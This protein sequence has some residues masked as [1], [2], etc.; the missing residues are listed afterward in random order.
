MIDRNVEG[1]YVCVFCFF[2]RRIV[3]CLLYKCWKVVV[4]AMWVVVFFFSRIVYFGWG[5]IFILD[6]WLGY[7]KGYKFLKML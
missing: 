7:R 2:F 6:L 5:R 1:M 3:F 4:I